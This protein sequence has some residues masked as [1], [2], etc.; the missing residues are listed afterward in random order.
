MRKIILSTDSGADIPQEY[1]NKYGIKVVPFVMTLEGKQYKDG[2]FSADDVVKTYETRKILPTTS[3]V[4]TYEYIEFFESIKKDNPECIVLHCS[5]SSELSCAYQNAYNAVDELEDVY[6]I[7]SKGVCASLAYLV[8]RLAEELE[9]NPEINIENLIKKANDL[10]PKIKLEVIP[11]TLNYLVA[12]GRISN[13]LAVGTSVLKINLVIESK[14]GKLTCSEKIRGTFVKAS[15]KKLES[16]LS[17]D[18]VNKNRFMI[19]RTDTTPEELL[20]VVEDKLSETVKETIYIKPGC[21][22]TTHLG[23]GSIGYVYEE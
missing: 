19:I 17:R 5:L 21:V 18:S 2:E 13:L 23:G 11:S 3:A 22:I 9:L 10:I 6:V 15:T 20:S 7:D 12:G 14:N 8:L 4:N 1:I 16:I